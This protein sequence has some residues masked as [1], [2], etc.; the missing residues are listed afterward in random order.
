MEYVVTGPR[1]DME[2]ERNGRDAIL[3]RVMLRIPLGGGR[4]RAVREEEAIRTRAIASRRVAVVNEFPAAIERAMSP[5]WTPS[6]G[7][8]LLVEQIT[9]LGA[10]LTIARTEYANGQ[11]AFDELLELQQATHR[12][13]HRGHRGPATHIRPIGPHQP[14]PTI[15]ITTGINTSPMKLQTLL[16]IVFALVVGLLGG[17]LFFG[18][19]DAEVM[20]DHTTD[21]V[22]AGGRL[23]EETIWTCSMHPQIQ[24]DEPRRLSTSVESTSFLSTPPPAATPRC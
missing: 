5:A 23:F 10:P 15:P 18:G 17:Y 20:D 11:R 1:T 3:P 22:A 12:L 14:L 21:A 19:A 7:W 9:T 2:P 24:R 13:P 4:Y 6:G 16:Y 8:Y